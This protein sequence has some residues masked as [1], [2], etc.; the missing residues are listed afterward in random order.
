MTGLHRAVVDHLILVTDGAAAFFCDE[1]LDPVVSLRRNAPLPPQVELLKRVR[2]ND[3]AA[4]H[5]GDLLQAAVLHD[6]TLFR[7][8]L[9]LKTSPTRGRFAVE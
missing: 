9:L 2:C 1:I 4:A 6:P 3:I 8:S 7:K 5:V